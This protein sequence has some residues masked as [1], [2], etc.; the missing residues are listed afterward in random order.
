MLTVFILIKEMGSHKQRVQRK[1]KKDVKRK[2]QAHRAQQ[3][4]TN[5][6]SNQM[7]E[8]MKMMAMMMNGK[9]PT[10]TN[11]QEKVN[12]IEE[13]QKLKQENKRIKES[14][15]MD[16][17]NREKHFLEQVNKL[18]AERL[19]AEADIDE[20]VKQGKL[21]AASAKAEKAKIERNFRLKMTEYEAAILGYTKEAVATE[22]E[23]LKNTQLNKLTEQNIKG[24][25]KIL[26]Y[27]KLKWQ[28]NDITEKFNHNGQKLQMLNQILPEKAD[29]IKQALTIVGKTQELIKD[30]VVDTLFKYKDAVDA[31]TILNDLGLDKSLEEVQNIANGLITDLSKKQLDVK[32]LEEKEKQL[33][34]IQLD[35][36][37][38]IQDINNLKEAIDHHKF[39]YVDDGNGKYHKKKDANGDDIPIDTDNKLADAKKQNIILKAEHES[40]TNELKRL[41]KKKKKLEDVEDENDDLEIQ[42]A[43]LDAAVKA[44]PDPQVTP[45]K[46]K[47][48]ADLKKNNANLKHKL[49]RKNEQ[50][51]R[52]NDLEK[53]NDEMEFKN[54]VDAANLNAQNDDEVKQAENDAV[55]KHVEV[56]V[57]KLVNKENSKL[58][59]AERDARAQEKEIEMLNNDSQIKKSNEQV[60]NAMAQVHV[61]GKRMKA[62]EQVENEKQKVRIAKAT[63]DAKNKAGDIMNSF[64]NGIAKIDGAMAAFNDE[65]D[66][67]MNVLK[68]EE[69]IQDTQ[70]KLR[71]RYSENQQLE[72]KNVNDVLEFAGKKIIE[73][74]EDVLKFNKLPSISALKQLTDIVDQAVSN[75]KSLEDVCKLE[76]MDAILA[77]FKNKGDLDVD[78]LNDDDL[79]A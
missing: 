78:E 22:N 26:D 57:Q 47:K 71:D 55:E 75:D 18:T 72:L 9:T 29:K 17:A 54:K 35:N 11:M 69:V 37:K 6:G 1:I 32:K 52:I 10:G 23:I 13:M 8:M 3:Q 74:P 20:L 58:L 38:T 25:K 66:K 73:T 46:F 59:D 24:V 48:N 77:Q 34:R 28:L 56:E 45:T 36:E 43:G 16:K 21:D 12:M 79:L 63:Y 31:E 65:I 19:K 49:D 2:A 61:Y 68:S 76:G 40:K 27:N 15:E 42:N 62:K 4:R 51:N 14:A 39:E 41:S 33:H 5:G 7:T 60:V 50:Q 67:N 30:K 44:T 53:E 70:K 64:D